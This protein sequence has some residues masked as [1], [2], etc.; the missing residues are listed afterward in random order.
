LRRVFGRRDA[1]P[2]SAVL[3]KQSYLLYALVPAVQPRLL[4]TFEADERPDRQLKQLN[5]NV[6]VGQVG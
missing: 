5:V 6:R 4:V 2:V 1:A 3:G